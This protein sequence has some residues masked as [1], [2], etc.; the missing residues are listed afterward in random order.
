MLVPPPSPPPSHH[1]PPRSE[2]H[3]GSALEGEEP[4]AG[5]S[6]MK[7]HQSLFKTLDDEH[8]E[9]MVQQMADTRV[10]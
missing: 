8:L 2:R 9:R 1:P 3:C 7:F 6:E 5:Y 4:R 10:R